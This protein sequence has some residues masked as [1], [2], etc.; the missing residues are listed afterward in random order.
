MSYMYPRPHPTLI[1]VFGLPNDLNNGVMDL[2]EKLSVLR[3]TS[4][5]IISTFELQDDRVTFMLDKTRANKMI[6]EGYE[7]VISS[8]QKYR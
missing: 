5:Q 3:T 7:V 2:R 1:L 4:I 6:Q 8:I